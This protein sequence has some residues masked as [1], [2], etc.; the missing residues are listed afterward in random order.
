M[1]ASKFHKAKMLDDDIKEL[2]VLLEKWDGKLHS[3]SSGVDPFYTNN[4]NDMSKDI[5][6]RI[7]KEIKI[8]Q[9]QFEEI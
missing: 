8:K 9:K 4:I 1:D 3:I 5:K 7:L 6:A 2:S